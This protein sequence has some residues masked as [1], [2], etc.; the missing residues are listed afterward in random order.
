MDTDGF[1][2]WMP[3]CAAILLLSISGWGLWE[4]PENTDIIENDS[5]D[6]VPR[7]VEYFPTEMNDD[8]PNDGVIRMAW[9][10][11]DNELGS[12]KTEDRYVEL[13]ELSVVNHEPKVATAQL[14]TVIRW[15][16]EDTLNVSVDV[17][18]TTEIEDG[19]LRLILIEN[20]VEMFGRTP[21]QNA[22][23]RMYDPTPIGS[24]NGTINREL[25]LTN[26]LSVDDAPRLRFVVLLS[27]MMTEENHA[28]TSM[29]VPQRNTGPTETGQRAS[30]LL[31]LGIIIFSLA[32]II[33][34]EWKREVMLPR[35]RGSRDA[36]G[37]PIAHLKAGRRDVQLREVRILSPWKFS[38]GVKS[39]DLPAGTEKVIPIQVKP[40][41]GNTEVLSTVIETEWSIEVEEMGGWVLDLTL[42]KEPPT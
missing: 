13:G 11:E 27:N 22:V 16:S 29:E 10:P 20:D 19:I 32:A 14:H 2:N 28:L 7:F 40:E 36:N 3:F 25:K 23:V 24:G 18:V 31:G 41:R 8:I 12:L 34:S 35:L 42:Y 26:G 17:N 9:Y 39:I 33:R 15:S 38:K 1:G 37:N 30:T 21:T 5:G 6:E 4:V